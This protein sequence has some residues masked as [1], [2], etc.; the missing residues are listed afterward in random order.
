MQNSGS[1]LGLEE[2]AARHFC[3]LRQVEQPADHRRDVAELPAVRQLSG[4]LRLDEDQRKSV[5]FAPEA[6]REIQVRWPGG[7]T[8]TNSIPAKAGEIVVGIDGVL[9]VSR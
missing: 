5:M 3:R 1:G 6:P 4:W 9:S 2:A 7:K 8:T